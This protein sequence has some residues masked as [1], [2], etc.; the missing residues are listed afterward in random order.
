MHKKSHHVSAMVALIFQ[1]LSYS[2]QSEQLAILRMK[3]RFHSAYG[4]AVS[5]QDGGLTGGQCRRQT[6]SKSDRPAACFHLKSV[7]GQRVRLLQEF[8][9]L[10]RPG[11]LKDSALPSG[12][13]APIVTRP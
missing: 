7:V 1:L 3:E 11:L 10:G 6:A 9:V 13:A 2:R 8:Q 4:H 12:S 5:E